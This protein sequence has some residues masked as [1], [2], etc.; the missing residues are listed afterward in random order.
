MTNTSNTLKIVFNSKIPFNSN[1]NCIYQVSCRDCNKIYVGE[2]CDLPRRAYQHRYDYR[3]GYINNVIFKH[4]YEENHSVPLND[5]KFSVV[6]K[7]DNTN[8][9]KLIESILIQNSINFNINQC[10]F[11]LDPFTNSYVK[12][13]LPFIK[14]I[15][16]KVNANSNYNIY[17][18]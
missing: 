3:N 16:N 15:L 12:H 14:N 18:T 13:Y 4:V 6:F 8:K 11:K 17:V 1:N 2:S 5:E 9:R 10:N 7:I